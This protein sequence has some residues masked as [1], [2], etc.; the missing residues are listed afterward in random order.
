MISINPAQ[1][2]YSTHAD[3]FANLELARARSQA[4]AAYFRQRVHH[5]GVYPY[6]DQPPV[7]LRMHCREPRALKCQK[8]SRLPA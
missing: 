6:S 1:A 8:L 3:A 7:L 5:H 4:H 2:P